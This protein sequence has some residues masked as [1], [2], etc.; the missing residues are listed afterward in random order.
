MTTNAAQEARLIANDAA[1]ALI[2][3][4]VAA[5]VAVR[6]DAHDMALGLIWSAR[7]THRIA[8]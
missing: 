8:A 3:S 7:R 2:A 5:T 4:T 6:V 1:L